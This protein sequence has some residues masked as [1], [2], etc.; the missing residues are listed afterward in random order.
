MLESTM[1]SQLRTARRYKTVLRL[2]LTQEQEAL[3]QK[4]YEL[5]RQA[6]A[7]GLGVLDMA[8]I[9][10]QALALCLSPTRLAHANPKPFKAAETFFMETL[11]PFEAAHRGF[12]KAND[13]LHQLN[14]ALAERNAA[15][16]RANRELAREITGRRRSEKA[17][18]ES[19][20][21]YRLLFRGAS[22]MEENLRDLSNQILHVQEA[23]RKRISRELHDEVGQALTALG[24]DLGM[25][26]QNG[27][28]D[29]DRLKRKISDMHT[30]LG[31]I[32]EWVH[33]FARELRPALLDELG[34][35]PALR[36]YLKGFAERTGLRVH[37]KASP[38]V[39]ALDDEQKTA[40]FRVCQE[41]LTNVA[42]HAQATR[43]TATLRQLGNGVRMQI[44][45]DGKA[46]CVE[47]QLSGKGKKR[48]GLLGMQERVRLVN[49]RFAIKSVP[50]KGT[51]V[52][53]DIPFQ[54]SGPVR[55]INCDKSPDRTARCK[56]KR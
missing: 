54:N 34:L 20:D 26:Q 18:R 6:I 55:L 35:L 9:H 41:S 22:V 17:L 47:R 8:R 42:R 46:F 44:S 50:G 56:C 39:E 1:N 27:A 53:I 29:G 40:L 28:V 5:G 45:D 38:E 2:Y 24:T 13:E 15:L 14:A 51:T 30:L 19:Q 49:G 52:A 16:A 3:L 7:T 25:L 23:E 11:S 21:H 31:Q 4:A 43:V 33:R 48:L 37:F 12:R 10:Q 32:I 36:S